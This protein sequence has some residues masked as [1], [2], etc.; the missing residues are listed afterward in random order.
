MNVSLGFT[1]VAI[2]VIVGALALSRWRRLTGRLALATLALCG[3]A[4][5]AGALL[6]QDD[7]R[8]VEWLVTLALLGSATPLHGRLVLGASGRREAGQ[9]VADAAP[10]A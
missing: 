4:A 1:L 8:A 3:I 9:V 10:A 5:G 2:A 7:V 6:L